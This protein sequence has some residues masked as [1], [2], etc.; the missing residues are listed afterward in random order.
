MCLLRAEWYLVF[1]LSLR[2]D[3]AETKTKVPFTK[4]NGKQD[5]SDC[6]DMQVARLKKELTLL[7]REIALVKNEQHQA[8]ENMAKERADSSSKSKKEGS[9]DD[10]V[11]SKK[12]HHK[13]NEPRHRDQ[14]LHH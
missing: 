14:D 8:K 13:L 6:S 3:Q 10:E 12:V 5:T 4:I 1:T 11:G 9:P 2:I 7:R